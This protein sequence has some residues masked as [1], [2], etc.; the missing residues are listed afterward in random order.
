MRTEEGCAIMLHEI[1][2]FLLWFHLLSHSNPDP[3]P[4]CHSAYSPA[5]V[6]L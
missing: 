1:L 3:S 2:P 5:N 6:A 4:C